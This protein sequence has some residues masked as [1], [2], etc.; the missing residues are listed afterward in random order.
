MVGIKHIG[1][2]ADTPRHYFVHEKPP[3]HQLTVLL[4]TRG[5][6][7][8]SSGANVPSLGTK[9]VETSRAPSCK[10]RKETLANGS[11]GVTVRSLWY[12]PSDGSFALDS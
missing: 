4:P 9:N 8:A 12:N 2:H 7:I 1:Q 5:T 6:I 3:H 10:K 11:L